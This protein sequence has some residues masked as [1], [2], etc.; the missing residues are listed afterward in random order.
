MHMQVAHVYGE[1]SSGSSILW[2]RCHWNDPRGLMDVLTKDE[3][4]Q[5]CMASRELSYQHL[6][7]LSRATQRL[8]K[9]MIVID[10]A[11]ARL[12]DLVEPRTTAVQSLVSKR[13]AVCYPQLQDA[14]L[15]VN[16]PLVAQVLYRFAEMTLDPKMMAKVKILK[17]GKGGAGKA[18]A[19]YV[20]TGLEG[21]PHFLDG[22][23][24]V[25]PEE[26]TGEL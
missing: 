3:F 11:G 19:P 9:Q 5:A 8:T 14:V 10:L 7:R 26:L 15:V 18:L 1:S 22:H 4:D 24:A 20:F 25:L 17:H 16:A 12:A 2:V 23:A 13:A 21:V 6:D